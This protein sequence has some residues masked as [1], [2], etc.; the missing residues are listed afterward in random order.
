MGWEFVYNVRLEVRWTPDSLHA[1]QTW[2]FFKLELR[3]FEYGPNQQI[4][5]AESMYVSL[6]IINSNVKLGI[7]W[8]RNRLKYNQEVLSNL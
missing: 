3:L 2:D 7:R 8:T 4:K 1:V 5:Q 6:D